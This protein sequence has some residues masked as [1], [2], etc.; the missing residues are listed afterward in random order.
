MA[1]LEVEG[2]FD[3]CQSMVKQAFLD[4]ELTAKMRLSSANSINI[5]RLI[6]QSFY[7][8]WAWNQTAGENR[9]FAVPSGN[10]GNLTAGLLAWTWGMGVPG[11]VAVTN[12]NDVVPEYLR[13]EIFTPRP[14][15]HT[16]SNAMDVGNP[17]NFERLTAIFDGKWEKMKRMI[18]GE[19]ITDEETLE[20]IARVKENTGYLM[21]PHTA[22]GYLGSRRFSEKNPGSRIITLSTAHPGKFQEVVEEAT[23]T[24]PE[25]PERLKSVLSLPKKAEKVG[26]HL[27]DLKANLLRRFA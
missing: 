5:G 15:L 22:V 20:T 25:L 4:R 3:D 7:Y 19:V 9:Y 18:H 21:D 16:L 6:P 11:F 17:S 8:L 2:S 24:A 13:T 10:F 14:S 26:N 27:G 23:G 1:A 12:R